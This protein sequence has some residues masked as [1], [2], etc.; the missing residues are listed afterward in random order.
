MPRDENATEGPVSTICMVSLTRYGCRASTN[1]AT[2]PTAGEQRA[3]D[4]VAGPRNRHARRARGSRGSSQN[5][6]K[7]RTLALAQP[8][9]RD[10]ADQGEPDASCGRHAAVVSVPVACVGGL[11]KGLKRTVRC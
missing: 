5:R 2:R 7:L 9:D 6:C 1:P 11:S 10:V 3:A 8:R 4:L